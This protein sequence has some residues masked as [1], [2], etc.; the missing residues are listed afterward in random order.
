MRNRTSAILLALL[1]ALVGASA[2]S[3]QE[4]TG[5]LTGKLT[6]TQGP[7]RLPPMAT[8]ASTRRSS[9]LELTP[10]APS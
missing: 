8:A 2:A 5:T 9:P 6:D 3:A 7:N 10:F 4:T 1:L